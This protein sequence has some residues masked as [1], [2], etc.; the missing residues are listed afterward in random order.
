MPKPTKKSTFVLFDSWSFH[1]ICDRKVQGNEDSGSRQLR[2][3]VFLINAESCFITNGFDKVDAE[4]NQTV[5]PQYEEA[6]E[7]FGERKFKSKWVAG[8]DDH[9]KKEFEL[10]Y[11]GNYIS[12]IQTTLVLVNDN[13][14]AIKRLANTVESSWSKDAASL[15]CINLTRSVDL[16][17][18][19]RLNM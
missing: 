18:Y 2:C 7:L 6:A 15:L 4:L 3:F 9:F 5:I 12:A 11:K 14:Q 1:D 10:K 19:H 13:L 16:L 8:F 17:V